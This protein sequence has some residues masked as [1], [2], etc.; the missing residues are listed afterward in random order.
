MF[1]MISYQDMII[2][3]VL[4]LLLFGPD[5]LPEIG[6]QMGTLLRE[7][8]NMTGDVQRTLDMA[9]TNHFDYD[10]SYNNR[11][12]SD[13]SYRA[14]PS[15]PIDHAE[16]PKSIEPFAYSAPASGAPV[17]S[18]AVATAEENHVEGEHVA[19]AGAQVYSEPTVVETKPAAQEVV[20]AVS[21]S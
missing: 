11:T 5:K 13:Y 20:S 1:A 8:R 4:A 10:R 9:G 21:V 12:Y 17:S 6:R 18:V 19:S 7:F 14:E 3:L 15:Y 16:E 2:I